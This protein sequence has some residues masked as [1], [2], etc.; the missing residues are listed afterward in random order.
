MRLTPV[1]RVAAFSR[2]DTPPEGFVHAPV[3]AIAALREGTG[4]RPS[5][6]EA[7]ESFGLQMPVFER[8]F[9]A[10]V[11]NPYG[12]A[13]ALTHP[14]GASGARVIVTLLNAMWALGHRHGAATICFASGGATGVGL[15]V[16]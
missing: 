1:A 12:G 3:E 5:I 10:Q 11:V 8:E 7:N 2:I 6:V 14:V 9:G 15:E 4:V 13:V 16:L